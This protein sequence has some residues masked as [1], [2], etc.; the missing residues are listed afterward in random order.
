MAK[1]NKKIN[2]KNS[3]LVEKKKKNTKKIVKPKKKVVKFE[4]KDKKNIFKK[5]VNKKKQMDEKKIEEKSEDKIKKIKIKVIGIGGGGGSIVSEISLKIKKNINFV[6]ANTDKQALKLTG[7]K[8]TRFSFGYDLTQGLGTGMNKE[9]GKIAAENEKEK[10]KK[11]L[12]DQD[13]CIFVSCL[14]GG[15][16]SGAVPIFAKIAKNLGCISYGI[17]TIPFKFE[18]EKKI[19]TAIETLEELRPHLNAMSIIPNDRIFQIVDK[20]T[21][22]KLAL[23]S[24]NKI[25]GEGLE[26]LLETIYSPGLINIDFADLKTIFNGR[27]RLTYLNSV[28]SY[29]SE[30][31]EILTKDILHSPL[32]PYSISGA[33]GILL[34]LVGNKNLELSE[35]SLISKSISSSVNKEAKIVL[36][37]GQ[38]ELKENKIRITLLATGCGQKILDKTKSKTKQEENKES[39]KSYKKEKNIKK[40]NKKKIN[41]KIEKKETEETDKDNI[42][43]RRNG[44]QIKKEIENTEKEIMT[45]DDKWETPAFLRKQYNK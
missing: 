23:S 30:K 43:K 1:K 6:V 21:P 32:Y 44:L 8:A 40:T 7:K 24:I 45:E 31:E 27:G 29:K 20:D 11:I 19:E 12:E 33:K 25:L 10:I 9:I 34:N 17:F 22:L 38:K 4:K 28:E 37:I 36:G 41:K 39:K 16:G 14:G 13:F 35:V 42:K 15:T 18:G 3:K 26:A 2:K 5:R